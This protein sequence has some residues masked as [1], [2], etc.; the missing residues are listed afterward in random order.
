MD[1][2]LIGKIIIDYSLITINN[3][4]RQWKNISMICSLGSGRFWL[5]N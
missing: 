4:Y 1:N 3:F 5:K 2:L